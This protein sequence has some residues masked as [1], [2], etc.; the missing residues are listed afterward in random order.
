MQYKSGTEIGHPLWVPI[1]S[2][3]L[4]WSRTTT[5]LGTGPQPAAYTIPPRGQIISFRMEF[6]TKPCSLSIP[7]DFWIAHLART[8]EVLRAVNIG[9]P[10][11]PVPVVSRMRNVMGPLRP[12][13][14]RISTTRTM[15]V[16]CS[17]IRKRRV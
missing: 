6:Y 3:A 16:T 13:R 9:F 2:G 17:P 7:I 8:T 5:P 1:D 14:S 10:S 12:E 11:L 4:E 15:Q